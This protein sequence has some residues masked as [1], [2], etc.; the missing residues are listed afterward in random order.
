MNKRWQE[1]SNKCSFD[2]MVLTIE[3]L[4]M[5][6]KELTETLESVKAEVASKIGAAKMEATTREHNEILT[7]LQAEV[8]ERKRKKFQ[9]DRNDYES[10][11]VYCWKE[12]R[13]KQR[14]HRISG[15]PPVN[16]GPQQRAADEPKKFYAQRE[17]YGGNRRPIRQHNKYPREPYTAESSTYTSTEDEEQASNKDGQHFLG[18]RPKEG[19]GIIEK[20]NPR[21]PI[22]REAY[23]QR[24]RSNSSRR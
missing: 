7:K 9:R 1:I 18:A 23:P 3:C 10:G 5:E 24:Y 15:S 14:L 6:M 16:S 11:Q 2:F 13:S 12:E 22:A 8:T 17:R 20:K 19:P 21:Y 4:D